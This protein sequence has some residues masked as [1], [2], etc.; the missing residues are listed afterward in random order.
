MAS[1]EPLNYILRCPS[2]RSALTLNIPPQ[3]S[4]D[5]PRSYELSKEDIDIIEE[6]VEDLMC[7]RDRRSH[8]A[9]RALLKKL[10]RMSNL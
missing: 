7:L 2:C 10:G 4:K 8:E 5:T 6:A 9:E 3:T 1:G